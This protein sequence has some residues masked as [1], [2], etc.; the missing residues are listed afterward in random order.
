MKV[1]F[2]VLTVAALLSFCTNTAQAQMS[3][4][5]KSLYQ[6]LSLLGYDIRPVTTPADM[7]TFEKLTS[8]PT[9]EGLHIVSS[10]LKPRVQA[11]NS[12][13][14]PQF[15][16]PK[17]TNQYSVISKPQENDNGILERRAELEPRPL[18]LQVKESIHHIDGEPGRVRDYS[19]NR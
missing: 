13:A 19:S 15:Y 12:A 6:R 16:N 11:F 1:A 10:D 4:Q 17:E 18:K 5:Q 8:R 7:S 9:Q 3:P 14:M 2:S